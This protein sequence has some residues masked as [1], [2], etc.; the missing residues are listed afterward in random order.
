MPHVIKVTGVRVRLSTVPATIIIV[1]L[2]LP[3]RASRLMIIL[4]VPPNELDGPK[5]YQN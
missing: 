2:Y 1:I 5:S 4:E 3:Q